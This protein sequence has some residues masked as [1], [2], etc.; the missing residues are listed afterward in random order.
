MVRTSLLIAISAL[1]C[2]SA[3]IIAC[4]AFIGSGKSIWSFLQISDI[5][6]LAETFGGLAAM[7][8]MFV[9]L[10]AFSQWKTEFNHSARHKALSDFLNGTW[11]LQIF[12]SYLRALEATLHHKCSTQ[13]VSDE[14]LDAASDKAR[15]EWQASHTSYVQ[16]WTALEIFLSEKEINTIPLSGPEISKKSSVFPLQLAVK[17]ADARANKNTHEFSFARHEMERK[18]IDDMNTTRAALKKLLRS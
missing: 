12:T 1:L 13:G 9:V 5:H 15:V 10:A 8:T 3:G 18:L 16:R 6:D 4:L 11:E 17:Y 14:S 7:V 2:F